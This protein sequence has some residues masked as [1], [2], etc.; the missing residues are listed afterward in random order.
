MKRM[1]LL[2]ILTASI[3][4]LPACTNTKQNPIV[5]KENSSTENKDDTNI[6]YNVEQVILSKGFQNLE[7]NVEIVKKDLDFR[8]LASLGLV[9]SSGVNV[10]K[11]QKSGNEINIYVKNETDE[12]KKHLVV[13]QVLIDLKDF[14]IKNRDSLKF[15]IVNENYEP[16]K[17]KLGV[18]EIVNKINS[19][20]KISINTFPLVDILDEEGKIFWELTYKNIF[21]IYN[22]E[23]PIINLSVLVDSNDGSIIQYSKDFISSYID[24]GYILDYI[25]NKFIIYKKQEMD[26]NH[27]PKE[28]ILW[29]YD[30]ENNHREILYSSK[31]KISCA[32]FNPDA[33]FVS[34]I[35]TN[36]KNNEL[37]IIGAQ[38]KKAYKIL[39]ANTISPKIIRWKDD[40][41]L[42]IID[43]RENKSYIYE[44]NTKTN[45]TDLV[46]FISKD[47][48]D[49]QIINDDFLISEGN[50]DKKKLKIYLTD[51]WKQFKFEFHGYKPSFI[52][53]DKIAY[54]KFNEKEDSNILSIYDLDRENL[55][56]N[57]NLNITKYFT[58][59]SKS[60]AL[61]EK[62]QAD[63]DF[64]L[65]R[66]D[67]KNK[68]ITPIASIN[69]D[70]VFYNDRDRLLYVNLSLPFESEKT[71]II[72]SLD[73][74]QID[75]EN[76]R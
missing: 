70:Q 31:N 76:P 19:D 29:I 41:N 16:I 67:I 50:E 18:N 40:E 4:F 23:T 36:D 28:E 35:D 60:L 69:S 51:N 5:F 74:S 27:N 66:Y 32:K 21:D 42:Y 73:L 34:L 17:I 14:K 22:N 25:P 63:N 9:E 11:I 61:I 15:N 49:L 53:H 39:F 2:F 52:D 3:S 64:T 55:Y 45:H 57:I 59:D 6:S 26:E 1:L 38:D 71:Q 24:E 65:H 13:P 10:T 75:E 8:L 68:E 72:Y 56:D 20:F 48:T 12:Q 58:L 44:H 43:S 7:P 47:I 46:H 37:Y 30:I 54:L 33:S 62:H